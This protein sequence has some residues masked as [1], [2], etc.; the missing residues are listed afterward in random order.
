MQALKDV[1]DEPDKVIRDD[2]HDEFEKVSLVYDRDKLDQGQQKHQK[3]KRCENRKKRC[4]CRIHGHLI[5]GIF[6]ENLFAKKNKPDHRA[7]FLRLIG[8]CI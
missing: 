1:K 5:P 6:I 7:A 8:D 2:M 4:L 3:R